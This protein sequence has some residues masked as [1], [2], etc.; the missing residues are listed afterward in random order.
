MSEHNERKERLRSALNYAQSRG[1]TIKKVAEESQIPYGTLRGFA[2]SGQLGKSNA[3]RLE[4][5]FKRMKVP[6]SDPYAHLESPR[7]LL[8]K[9]LANLSDILASPHYSD[10]FVAKK[11]AAWV[12]VAFDGLP[13]IV[14]AFEES[15]TIGGV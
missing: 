7:I 4:E 10:D 15:D 11:F 1:H 6:T 13:D 2:S 5:W 8:A 14:K 3:A 12:K 9:D